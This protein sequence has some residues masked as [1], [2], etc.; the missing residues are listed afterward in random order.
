MTSHL[1]MEDIEAL[2]DEG[3]VVHPE[4]VVRLNALALKIEKRPDFRLATL[5]R[6]ALCGGVLF[7]QPTIA[8][9]IFIDQMEEV[10]NDDAGTKLAL[11]AYVLAHRDEDWSKLP[12]FPKMFATKCAIW[13]RLHL[14]RET[15]SKV[16]QALDFCK[17]GFNQ[18]DGEWPVLVADETF[19]KWYDDAGPLSTAMK[20]YIQA[21]TY[22]IASEAA[23][24]ATSQKLTA[25]IERAAMLNDMN[26]SESEKVATAE[27]YMTLD[28][29]KKKAYA[30]R[31]VKKNAEV[32]NG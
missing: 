22:G 29:V 10:L 1:A 30:E 27:Y 31:D 17:Y 32:K 11:E 7:Q 24:R 18:N 15:A 28:E 21:C 25:M 13:I 16:R 6:V 19:S 23:L 2:I 4:D 5:P 14:G 3:C 9:D 8:Q 12:T 26:I 20:K